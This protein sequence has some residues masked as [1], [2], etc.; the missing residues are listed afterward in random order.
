[1]TACTTRMERLSIPKDPA[2]IDSLP[3]RRGLWAE[4][5]HETR[6]RLA[7]AACEKRLLAWVRQ[8]LDA[9]S[10]AQRSAIELH[11]FA[12]LPL[13]SV[14]SV[15]QRSPSTVL[16]AEKR[17]I[18]ALRALYRADP[19]IARAVH[20]YRHGRRAADLNAEVFLS[21]E[22]EQQQD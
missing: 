4:L 6:Y 10:E 7:R 11:Y 22:G 15:V 19:G 18:R 16:R 12:R 14:G 3:A 2:W 13:R 1:M 5:P 17:A 20:F 9:L 21:V 8:R